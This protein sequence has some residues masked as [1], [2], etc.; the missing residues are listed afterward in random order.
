MALVFSTNNRYIGLDGFPSPNFS[1]AWFLLKEFMVNSA[2]WTIVQ[3]GT[4]DTNTSSGPHSNSGDVITD[5]TDGYGGLSSSVVWWV[6]RDPGGKREFLFYR[7]TAISNTEYAPGYLTASYMS[8][9]YSAND[10][11]STT[12]GLG[13][14]PVSADNPPIANDMIWLGSTDRDT[15][16]GIGASIATPGEHNTP[17]IWGGDVNYSNTWNLHICASTTAPYPFYFW[18]TKQTETL[19]FFCMDALVDTYTEDT[20]PVLFYYFPIVGGPH[21]LNNSSL[22]TWY[23]KP[24]SFASR[25]DFSV[26]VTNNT[27]RFLPTSAM[28]F[29]YDIGTG[30]SSGRHVA[31]PGGIPTNI[32]DGHDELFPVSYCRHS[33]TPYQ[34]GPTS[35]INS[36]LS[37]PPAYKGSSSFL[38]MLGSNR[39]QFDV[40]DVS[41]VR[42]HICVGTPAYIA[43]PWDGSIV[44][45]A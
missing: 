11:F 26:A 10:R 37:L 41:T 15:G 28:W 3:S 29:L 20:D 42:D 16:T 32:Y 39:E 2:G 27:A 22:S 18:F 21:S 35:P 12:L 43:I 23:K 45:I 36:I 19:S 9:A 4:Y 14:N 1:K 30:L 7:P 6:M 8:I 13:G 24:A 17:D 31:I 25:S 44:N 40:F 5:A 38:R 33:S 34:I